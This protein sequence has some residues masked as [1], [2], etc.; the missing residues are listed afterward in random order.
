[1]FPVVFLFSHFLFFL[2]PIPLIRHSLPTPSSPVRMLIRMAQCP[3]SESSTMLS[4][5]NSSTNLPDTTPSPPT[6]QEEPAPVKQLQAQEQQEQEEQG[7]PPPPQEQPQLEPPQ[8]GQNKQARPVSEIFPNH[9]P[10]NG[11]SFQSPEGKTKKT[12]NSCGQQKQNTNQTVNMLGPHSCRK[13]Q[14][15]KHCHIYIS[16]GQLDLT[17]DNYFL[18]LLVPFFLFS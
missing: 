3:A 7:Q 6:P 13:K 4:T 8:P 18:S 10:L 14:T 5:E 15:G 17:T 1:M 16:Q 12:H 2:W 11:K 9:I